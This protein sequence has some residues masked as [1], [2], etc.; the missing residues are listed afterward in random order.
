MTKKF[1]VRLFF[2][3]CNMV[4]FKRQ[5]RHIYWHCLQLLTVTVSK[6]P[7]MCSFEKSPPGLHFSKDFLWMKL[8]HLTAL[9]TTISF[10]TLR[11]R[12]DFFGPKIE[13]HHLR[14]K[15][16]SSQRSNATR[17]MEVLRI[18]KNGQV[19]TVIYNDVTYIYIFDI[20]VK[21]TDKNSCECYDNLLRD[22]E[23]MVKVGDKYRDWFKSFKLEFHCNWVLFKKWVEYIDGKHG[24]TCQSKMGVL[25]SHYAELGVA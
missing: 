18:E 6:Y 8:Q 17:P 24:R 21:C 9:V 4:Y 7:F 25:Q 22:A 3:Y 14:V 19:E 15:H 16:L 1:F 12:G 11:G 13:F 10:A 20:L 5:Q 2:S 23:D